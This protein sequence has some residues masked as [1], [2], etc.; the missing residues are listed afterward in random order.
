[1][2]THSFIYYLNLTLLLLGSCRLNPVSEEAEEALALARNN[3]AE[4]FQVIQHYKNK[5]DTLKLKAAFFLIENMV[6]KS[7][8]SGRAI[9]EYYV[10]IDSVYQIKQDEYDIPYICQKFRRQAKFMKEMPVIEKDLQSLT[11]DYLIQNIEEAFDVWNKPWNKH[12]SF[13]EFC[14]YLLP[15]RVGT[16]MPEEWRTLY[17]KRF[18]YLLQSDTIRT[19]KDACVIINNEL[20]KYPMRIATSSML[21]IGMRPRTL[22]NIKFGQCG[23]YTSLAVYAMRSVGIPVAR[24]IIPHWGRKNGRHVFNV[25]YNNDGISYN[26][27]GAEQN[28]E[29]HYI[30]VENKIPKIYRE[31]FS[32]QKNSLAVL[33]GNE[34]IPSFFQNACLTDVTE[35][36]SF[37]GVKDV[38]L[39][40][41][42]PQLDKKYAYLCVFDATTWMPVAWSKIENE[43]VLFKNVGPDIVYCTAL[44]DDGAIIPVGNPFLLDTLGHT[45]FY[46][47]EKLKTEVRYTIRNNDEDSY[48]GHEY[49]LF[50]M[51]EGAWLSAGKEVVKNNNQIVFEQVPSN[52]LYWLRNQTNGRVERIFEI[53][54]NTIIWH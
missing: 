51:H 13:E 46:E 23:D 7:F 16:E 27:G 19:A 48:K 15:Y 2:S 31:T 39:T 44:Y 28:T 33:H 29:E 5:Q 34:E 6:D 30:R 9:D 42:H 8:L 36:Y 43:R 20:I 22:F 1:M 12:L 24:E 38:S 35:N 32:V 21:S 49:E 53:K 25:V 47:P 52:A 3:R 26:F 18:N 4:L 45:T 40:I 54:K 14:E 37:I 11:A 41:G 10:Y 50:Y 17:Y